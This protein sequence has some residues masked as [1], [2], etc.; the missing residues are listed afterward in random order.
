VD[1]VAPLISRFR[2][3]QY[4]ALRRWLEQEPSTPSASEIVD[5]GRPHFSSATLILAIYGENCGY[6]S[7]LMWVTI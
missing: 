2:H 4:S 6:S 7:Q 1:G 3:L 5:C